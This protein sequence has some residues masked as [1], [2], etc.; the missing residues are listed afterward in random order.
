MIYG[1]PNF[2]LE[3]DVVERRAQLLRDGG[4][5]FH[6]NVN[7]GKDV[8][9]EELRA[10]HDAVLIATGVYKARD[11]QVPGVGLGNVVDALDYLTASNRKGLGDDVP[12]FD[13]GALDATGK[14]V[15]VIGGGDTAMDCVRTA[16]RQGAKSVK[17]LY[18]RDRINMPGSQREVKHA[19]EEG[20]EF[21]W[22]AAPRAFLGDREVSGVRALRMHLGVAEATGRRAPQELEGSD[23][24]LPAD[25][26]IKA[27]GFDPEDMVQV[28]GRNDV[29]LTN[30][31]TLKIDFRTMM[32][33]LDGVFAAGD[34][35]RGASLVVW[36]VRDGRD[37]AERIHRHIQAKAQPALAKA[38]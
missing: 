15:V 34:I 19:E 2:K 38:S 24:T 6:L 22:L 4:V 13:S 31:G 26:T 12:A 21:V 5:T 14:N 7:I 23:F 3:K 35:V 10:R 29:A 20:V 32:T 36:A 30:W 17:C 11:V 33:N 37:A 25:L 8:S 27:L 1:I 16:V 9:V 18:R 28:M